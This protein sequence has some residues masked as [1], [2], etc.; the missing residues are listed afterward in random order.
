MEIIILAGAKRMFKAENGVISISNF[1]LT[2]FPGLNAYLKLK[3]DSMFSKNTRNDD[4]EYTNE[5]YLKIVFKNC[6]SGEQIQ[7]TA[8]NK[9]IQGSYTLKASQNCLDCLSGAT[10]KGGN[11]LILKK[12]F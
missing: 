1:T 3:S 11:T 2:G 10:C 8:C 7:A 12:G 4:T 6:S 9:C 5:A